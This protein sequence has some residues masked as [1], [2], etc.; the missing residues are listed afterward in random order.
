MRWCVFGLSLVLVAAALWI[1][2]LP[3][4]VA[5]PYFVYQTLYSFAI[6][7]RHVIRVF[8]KFTVESGV[9]VY[10]EVLRDGQRISEPDY[11]FRYN[12]PLHD[13]KFQTVT[14]ADSMAAV[15]RPSEPFDILFLV[16]VRTLEV[17][18]QEDWEIPDNYRKRKDDMLERFRA[19]TKESRYKYWQDR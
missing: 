12:K 1:F 3:R 6:D 9:V 5:F 18:R 13:L 14:T 15:V 8:T 17:S 16:D 19:G 10:C 7:E 2:V 4:L 11:L